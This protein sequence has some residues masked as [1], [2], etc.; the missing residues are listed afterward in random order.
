M[1]SITSLINTSKVVAHPFLDVKFSQQDVMEL[2]QTPVSFD[3]KPEDLSST[4]NTEIDFF[5]NKLLRKDISKCSKANALMMKLTSHHLASQLICY[6]C[7]GYEL[8][9]NLL[10]CTKCRE[11]FHFYCHVRNAHLLPLRVVSMLFQE[12]Q[13]TRTPHLANR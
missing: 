7:G 11:T 2:E 3:D 4:P 9:N 13:G 1:P 12:I 8:N 5:F 10:H 6:A